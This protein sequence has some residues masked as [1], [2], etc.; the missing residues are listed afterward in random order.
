MG[1]QIAL[2]R[3]INLGSKNRIG[4]P[5][6]REA[7]EAAGFDDVRTYVQSGNIVLGTDLTPT[8]LADRCHKVIADTFDLDIAV[9]A[10][11]RDE[12]AEV[13]DRNP[14]RDVA[15]DPKRY[16]VCFL[17]AEVKPAVLEKLESAAADSER[18][19][20]IGRELYTWHPEGSRAI[21]AVEPG[22]RAI[23]RRRLDLAQLED[24]D[25]AARNG[26]RVGVH[27]GMHRYAVAD[28]FTKTPLEGNQLAVFLDANGL[29]E[30]LMQ[31][32]ARELHLSETTF[33]LEPEAEGADIRI[34]IFTPGTELP[35][36]GHPVLGSAV[37]LGSER[38]DADLI[39][40]ETGAGIIP[41]TLTRD[42]D[43]TITFGEMDQ[44][45]PRI[46]P[47]E[48]GAELLAALGVERSEL[49]IETYRNGPKHV[50]VVLANAAAVA[51]L[52]PNLAA[53]AALG[54]MGVN[55]CAVA[56][57]RRQDPELLTG[58]RRPGG[59][60]HRFRGRTARGPPGAARPHPVRRADRDPAR[61]GNRAPVGPVRPG[62]RVCG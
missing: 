53:L 51:A 30:H 27:S 36:A 59:P 43:G 16:Q 3:G 25:G 2:L 18:V 15:D 17:A 35:F 11:T 48:H 19:V 29:D 54:P 41:V 47:Y 14:L 8:R 6:L 55:V 39:R 5:A 23:S 40:L 21:E 7:L 62:G 56:D 46:T 57:G 20:A 9:V 10:R 37:V 33:V 13:V 38:P 24:C 32:A 34:R 28:V 1:T 22:R 52:R 45:V 60:C 61:R 31:R 44:P 49:P 50:Y 12:L 58:A 26:R 4:M 42:A